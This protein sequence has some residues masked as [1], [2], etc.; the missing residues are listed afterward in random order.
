MRGRG[1]LREEEDG[2]LHN[3]DTPVKGAVPGS[4]QPAPREISELDT[5]AGCM[6][7]RRVGR[8]EEYDPRTW[9]LVQTS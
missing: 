9:Q 7:V 5:I 6:A 2:S 1:V 8:G 4:M 3:A